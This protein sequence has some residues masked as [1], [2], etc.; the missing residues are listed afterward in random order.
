MSRGGRLT[1]RTEVRRQG[2]VACVVAHVTD[3][4]TGIPEEHR[5][6]IF[7]TFFTTKPEGRGTGLG[8]A[9]TRDIVKNHEGTIEVDSEPGKG[10]TMIVSLPL[11]A[12][13]HEPRPVTASTLG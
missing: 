5:E 9:V 3:T 6:K 8:L 7:E 11:A 4:G 10:T 12:P 2:D 13:G 1:V